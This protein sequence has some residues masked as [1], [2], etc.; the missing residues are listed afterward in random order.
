MA[1]PNTV[2]LT[3]ANFEAEVLQSS[4]P[5]VVDFWASWCGPCQMIAPV[6][7]ELAAEYAGRVKVGKVDVDQNVNVAGKYGVQSIP[8]ILLFNGG[9]VAQTMVGA[10]HKRDYVSAIQALIGG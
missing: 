1:G 8:T 5:V 6:V 3:D 7:D 4:I 9:K 10:K 2:E